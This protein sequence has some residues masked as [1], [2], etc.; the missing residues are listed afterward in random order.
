MEPDRVL[1]LIVLVLVVMV[2]LPLFTDWQLWGHSSTIEF[3]RLTEMDHMIRQGHLYPRWC[4]DFY[5]GYGSPLF[6]F[7]AM[8]PYWIAEIFLLFGVSVLWALKMT[9]L[10]GFLLAGTGMFF[11]ARKLWGPAGGAASA[12]L[13][14]FSP[15]LLLDVYVRSSLGEVYSFAWIPLILFLFLRGLDGSRISMILGAL[16]TSF[17][18][19]THNIT[20]MLFFPML[21]LFVLLEG[22]SRRDWR[23]L[24]WALGMCVLALG[25]VAFFWLPA[26]AEKSFVRGN[27]DLITG[28]FWYG[29]HFAEIRDLFEPRWGF[30]SSTPGDEISLQLGLVHWILLPVAALVLIRRRDRR[31]PAARWLVVVLGAA[32][33]LM[34]PFSGFLW[35]AIQPLHF[36]QFPWRLLLLAT[37]ASSALGGA[38]FSLLEGKR[39][40]WQG[41]A[42]GVVIAAVLVAYLP[43]RKAQ[44]VA[45]DL[46]THKTRTLQK[47]ELDAAA[48]DPE[49][50]R[51]EDFLTVDLMRKIGMRA[52][53]LDDFLPIWVTF[54]PKF[55]PERSFQVIEGDVVVEP[56]IEKPVER[57][58]LVRST[59]GGRVELAT[60]WFPGWVGYVDGVEIDLFPQRPH[61]RL[62]AEIPP[63]EHE[64]V[65]KFTN[66]P[67]RT[68]GSVISL[69]SLVCALALI[70]LARRV[71]TSRD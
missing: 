55:I 48:A 41:L 32:L 64:L 10:L 29:H 65:V 67:V 37:F 4:A 36:V 45:A 60:F 61:G 43:Y 58:Y 11:F 38:A 49:L 3:S 28:D 16:F 70:A 2:S 5:Y 54:K 15:Y 25:L 44:F 59:S 21:I 13:Y 51:V 30:G 66:T 27:E 22:N 31:G 46:T 35:S 42:L 52:T 34:L 50:I 14:L 1:Y 26:L 56:L 7:Y 20:A 24:G 6:N 17:L 23:S 47:H 19:Y 68:A 62:E 71:H 63:G 53:I 57:T 8:L 40:R 39:Q 33:L 18:V 9:Y 69:A 12:A